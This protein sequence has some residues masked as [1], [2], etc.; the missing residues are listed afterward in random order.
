VGNQEIVQFLLKAGAG[1][2]INVASKGAQ[3]S[4]LMLAAA[5][6]HAEIIPDLLAAGAAAD[7][8]DVNGWTAAHHVS[9]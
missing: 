2:V 5:G 6:G 4:P 3:M 9:S 7:T 8:V 1:K